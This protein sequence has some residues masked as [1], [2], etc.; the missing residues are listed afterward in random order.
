MS[1]P[2]GYH[3]GTEVLVFAYRQLGVTLSIY[4]FTCNVLTFLFHSFLYCHFRPY[5]T[6][7]YA[8]AC[9]VFTRHTRWYHVLNVRTDELLQVYLQGTKQRLTH[10]FL[11]ERWKHVIT[12][13]VPHRHGG[14]I[15]AYRQLGVTF[16]NKLIWYFGYYIFS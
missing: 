7:S 2:C 9:V 13:W 12:M 8:L 6:W 15:F 5:I 14:F 1:L 3:I 16:L 10:R 4:Y 11:K